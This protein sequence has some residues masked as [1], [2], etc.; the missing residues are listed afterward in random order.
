MI[1]AQGKRHLVWW[2]S[3]II[4]SN[5]TFFFPAFLSGIRGSLLSLCWLLSW[6]HRPV[7]SASILSSWL[8]SL[9]PFFRASSEVQSCGNPEWGFWL[10]FIECQHEP[11]REKPYPVHCGSSV[12][13]GWLKGSLI[14]PAWAQK[15]VMAPGDERP[16]GINLDLVQLNTVLVFLSTWGQEMTRLNFPAWQRA[17]F[18]E[19][20]TDGSTEPC[21]S[22]SMCL[23]GLLCPTLST[24]EAFLE[25]LAG[26]PRFRAEGVQKAPT[27]ATS[28]GLCKWGVVGLQAA[29][30]L[31]FQ[32]SKEFWYICQASVGEEEGFSQSPQGA[33]F[34]NKI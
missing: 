13:W 20:G 23:K 11:F 21:C 15:W 3:L 18:G 4:F 2:S 31:F 32:G 7:L 6:C 24:W 34:L 25:K 28:L 30:L 5:F 33:C 8:L 17:E 1:P 16:W 26:S 9:A 10:Y 19:G 22:A 12:N 14:V 29:T 27:K